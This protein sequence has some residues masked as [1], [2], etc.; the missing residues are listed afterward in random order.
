MDASVIAKK[1][2]NSV[3][4]GKINVSELIKVPKL[5]NCGNWTSVEIV[6]AIDYKH[7][8]PPAHYKGL[9]VKH[10]GGLYYISQTLVDE[11]S[12]F[13]KNFS[14]VKSQITVISEE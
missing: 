1:Y 11:L 12:K 13:Q 10:N 14:K 7:R 9:L 5:V 8:V 3:K 4:N 6:G 2:A